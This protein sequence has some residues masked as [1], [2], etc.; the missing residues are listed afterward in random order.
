MSY[1]Y[2]GDDDLGERQ[3]ADELTAQIN[4]NRRKYRRLE[5]IHRRRVL[6]RLDAEQHAPKP[7]NQLP[8]A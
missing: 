6:M 3:D 5:E 7:L 4:A 2:V 1:S 8:E